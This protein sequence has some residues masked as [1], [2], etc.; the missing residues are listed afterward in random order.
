MKQEF[1]T[2]DSWQIKWK[3]HCNKLL[4]NT[5]AIGGRLVHKENK[6][7]NLYPK[8]LNKQ[9]TRYSWTFVPNK[10]KHRLHLLSALPK[11]EQKASILAVQIKFHFPCSSLTAVSR[12]T[13][14]KAKSWNTGHVDCDC[15]SSWKPQAGSFLH[16]WGKH[17]DINW[18]NPIN[19]TLTMP[20]DH[21]NISI[22]AF[23]K[24]LLQSVA[25]SWQVVHLILTQSALGRKNAR[26]HLDKYSDHLMM[27]V[28]SEEVRSEDVCWFPVKN[29]NLCHQEAWSIHQLLCSHCLLYKD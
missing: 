15:V 23:C 10:G 19:Q 1:L 4:T 6:K 28:I 29:T 14:Y 8:E 18:N 12:A 9:V 27:P 25:I 5:Q 26:L 13:Q 16:I 7:M 20:Q 11:W 21:Q 2:S 3:I 17:T 24:L 22:P